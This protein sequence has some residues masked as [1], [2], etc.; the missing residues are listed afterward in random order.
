MIVLLSACSDK[1][2]PED[3]FAEYVSHWNKQDFDS[4][5]EQLSASTKEKVTREEFSKRYQNIYSGIEAENVKITFNKP[6]EEVETKDKEEITF[7]YTVSMDTIAGKVEFSHKAIVVKEEL[8]KGYNWFVN[9]DSTYIFPQL[10]DGQEIKVSSSEPLRGEIYDRNGTPLAQNGKVYEV[11]IEPGKLGEEKAT[12]ITELSTLLQLSVEEIEGKLNEGWVKPDLFVPIKKIDPNNQ[13]LA[14]KVSSLNGVF[15]KKEVPSRYY[16]LGESAAHLIGYVQTISAEQLEQMKDKDY[17][18]SSKVGKVGLEQVFEE[19]LRGKTGWKIFIPDGEVIAEKPAENGETI[20]LTIDATLQANAFSQLNGDAGSVVAINPKTG[21]TLAL[22]SS[23]SYNPNDFIFGMSGATWKSLNEHPFKPLMARFNKTYA[24]GSTL[25]PL[26][27][28]IGLTTGVTDPEEKMKIEGKEWAKD[29]WGGKTITRVSSKLDSVNLHDALV[30]SDNIY[31]ART[32]L[33][34]GND[35]FAQGLQSFGFGEELEYEF[36]T[37]KST[38]TNEGFSSEG[39]LADSGYGQG[40][41]QMSPIHLSSTYSVFVNSGSMVKPYL[42]K[43]E[44]NPDFWKKDILSPEHTE[45]IYKSLYDVI[46]HPSGTGYDPVIEG[47]NIAG[48]TGT[49]E[50]KAS[51]DIAGEEN[52]WFVAVNQDASLLI[53]M[54]I[55]NVKDRGGSHYTVPKVK[56]LFR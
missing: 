24:P 4:M 9:W 42:E 1:P 14:V 36:P 3:R 51:K 29:N 40:E 26:T 33:A 11:G 52:G 43:K 22:V 55:E 5:Y 45:F 18:R 8:E 44:S 41:V 32:A 39:L 49:A 30:T 46:N 19:R 6:K 10:Q 23:P 13:D 56:E 48:K 28:S 53:T 20:T 38:V 37:A 34:I 17:T 2:K 47:V 31:F 7:P 12:I 50:L 21:E 16:P 15:L 54:M 27:A 35:K 25:K